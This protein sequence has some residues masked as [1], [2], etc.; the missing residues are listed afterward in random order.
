MAASGG[1][2]GVIANGCSKRMRTQTEGIIS[3]FHENII[4]RSEGSVPGHGRNASPHWSCLVGGSGEGR[5][6]RSIML[7]R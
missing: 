5:G 1:N 6:F 3:K 2:R 4:A 7:P